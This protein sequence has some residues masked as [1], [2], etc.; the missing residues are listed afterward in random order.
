LAI[1]KPLPPDP[2]E[3]ADQIVSLSFSSNGQLLVGGSRDSGVFLWNVLTGRFIRTF[4]R[5]A[6]AGHVNISSVAVS[7]DGKLVV[8]G[9]SERARSSGD[10][11]AER[12]VAVWD[13]ATG[14]RRFTLRGHED[15]VRAVG[16]SANDEWIVSASYDG[17]IRYW[18]RDTGKWVATFTA[19]ADGRWMMITESGL[20]AGSSDNDELINVIRGLDTFSVAQ[21]RQELYRPDLVKQLLT[22]DP[23]RRYRDAAKKLSL[24]T[25]LNGGPPPQIELLSNR[26]QQAG[27]TIRISVRIN[28][29]GGGIGP[30]VDWRVN[31]V[32]AGAAEE[33][34][35]TPNPPPTNYR[36]DSETLTIDPNRKNVITVIAY[37]GIGQL[38]SEPFH[39]NIDA[40]GATSAPR[41]RMFGIAVGVSD[42]VNTDWK[43]RYAA[44]DAQAFADA[45]KAAAG[46]IY[47]DVQ[48]RVVP[49]QQATRAGLAAAFAQI[50]GVI[51]ASDVF[52]LFVAGHGR[53][54]ESTGTYY[55]LQ[56]DLTF[57]SQH[58]VEDGIGQD[59][60]QSWLKQIPAQKSILIFDTCESA[61]AAG[62]TRGSV[63]QET[64]IDR[65]R[66][67]TGRSV[68]T[69]ARQAAYEG[70]KGHGVLTYAI[71]DTFTEKAPGKSDE[72]DLLQ[73]A[74]SVYH[75]VPDISQSL[76]G[77]RQHPI[78]KIE[79]NFPIGMTI[80]AL[81]TD[82]EETAIS[83]QPT[84]VVTR[85]ERLRE[86]PATD[87]PGDRELAPGT[88]VRVVELSGDWAVVARDGQKMGYV[89]IAA[90]LKLQ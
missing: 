80:P 10:I 33:G 27:D 23:E 77:V 30:K 1:I 83:P 60:W 40:S 75:E 32:T 89:P 76:F 4:N 69:A 52:V 79:G 31:G 66:D 7:H 82:T 15:G 2:S 39:I 42:Y 18:D 45:M 78:N 70:Y 56:R 19:A 62:L 49:E 87:A 50:K 48:I 25:I 58:S 3:A 29:A 59:T 12:G 20:F 68:I 46:R 73:L 9:Q 16:F 84:H 37:N 38:A 8:A 6:L 44:I 57:D 51:K 43:L 71:L 55:F 86:R 17:T 64:A 67:A 47:A 26:T 13:A 34:A 85:T 5:S 81:A 24:E 88:L 36:V 63:E 54:V 72:V 41:P 14:Q 53:T 11:G 90:L 35:P 21:F 61:A 22:G 65:L 74:A 28:D